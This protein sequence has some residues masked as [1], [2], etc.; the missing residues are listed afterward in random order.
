MR[1][2]SKQLDFV[3]RLTDGMRGAD[4]CRVFQE[5]SELIIFPSLADLNPGRLEMRFSSKL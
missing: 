2:N 3:D 4:H 1:P 5:D